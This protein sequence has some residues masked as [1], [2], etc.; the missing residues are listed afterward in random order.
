MY[1]NTFIGLAF[2]VSIISF[3]QNYTNILYINIDDLGWSDLS[4]YGSQFYETPNIDL[5]AHQGIKFTDA[6][7]SAANCA[8]SRAGLLSGMYSPRHGIYTVNSSERGKSK[9]RKLIPTANT[10]TLHDS[11]VTIAETLNKSGYTTASIGKWHLGED[12]KTQGFDINIGGTH[13]GHPASYFSPYS[14]KNLSDGAQG[15]YLTDRLTDEAISFLNRS[16][17]TPFFY[18]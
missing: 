16:Q 1:R 15:E 7:A 17:N 3:S 18:I 12:P 4:C 2:L 10:L 5:L 9:H 8:P 14:N 6:Y 13:Q 11:I